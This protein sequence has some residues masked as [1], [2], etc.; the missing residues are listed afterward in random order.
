MLDEGA[1]GHLVG[2]CPGEVE[3]TLGTKV[4]MVA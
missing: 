3:L 2:A 4:A 1:M